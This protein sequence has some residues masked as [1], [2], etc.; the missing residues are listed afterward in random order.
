MVFGSSGGSAAFSLQFL[1]KQHKSNCHT[2][3]HCCNSFFCV[4][5]KKLHLRSPLFSWSILH[6]QYQNMLHKCSGSDCTGFFL[7]DPALVFLH[8]PKSWKFICTYFLDLRCVPSYETC[9][10]ASALCTTYRPRVI[11][12]PRIIMASSSSMAASIT[13]TD[14][15]ANLVLGRWLGTHEFCND[16]VQ[17]PTKKNLALV[18]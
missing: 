12:Q 4:G 8:K 6:C 16:A 14:N 13:S 5:F 3:S 11:A 9:S 18:T 1:N 7:K 10:Y 2:K 15:R 17:K